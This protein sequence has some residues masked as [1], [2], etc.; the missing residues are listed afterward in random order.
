L[1]YLAGR[2][3]KLKKRVI[4]CQEERSAPGGGKQPHRYRPGTVALRETGGRHGVPVLCSCTL[5]FRFSA[6]TKDGFPE[7]KNDHF[8][9]EA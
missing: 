7:A 6:E 9:T 5:V 3:K 4:S 1:E 2:D 8:L